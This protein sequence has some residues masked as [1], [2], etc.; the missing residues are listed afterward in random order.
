[1]ALDYLETSD[2]VRYSNL[3]S[4]M[5]G[6]LCRYR[7]LRPTLSTVRRRGVRRRFS[8]EDLLLARA[9]AK[10]LSAKVELSSVR[11]ALRTLRSKMI[12]VPP[13]VLATKQ[14]VIL[15]K[16]VYLT[17]LGESAVELTA[18][19]QLAFHFMLDTTDVRTHARASGRGANV[20]RTD[21]KA[22][23]NVR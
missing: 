18:D 16:S 17:R 20:I 10:L 15:G 14:I 3:S 21:Q 22:R 23:R 8:F 6:Y 12:G 9:I 1:M 2:I 5:V 11:S 7:I 19:G 4:H 13:S